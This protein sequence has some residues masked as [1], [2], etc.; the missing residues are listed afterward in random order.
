[1]NFGNVENVLMR[2]V[3]GTP[4]VGGELERMSSEPEAPGFFDSSV[5]NKRQAYEQ[6]QAL[7]AEVIKRNTLYELDRLNNPM[8]LQDVSTITGQP[9]DVLATEAQR[10]IPRYQDRTEQYK[11]EGPQPR[12]MVPIGKEVV[13]TVR[14]LTPV[15]TPRDILGDNPLPEMGAA[16][17]DQYDKRQA[18]YWQPGSQSEDIT[19]DILAPGIV[20][21][22][23]APITKERTVREIAGYDPNPRADASQWQRQLAEAKI[24]QQGLRP[25]VGAG[26][27]KPSS[28]RERYEML[29]PFVGEEEAARIVG[30]ASNI[31]LR[32]QQT[33]GN[34]DLMGAKGENLK[35]QTESLKATMG[36]RADYY[37]TQSDL[38]A[39]RIRDMKDMSSDKKAL[40]QQQVKSGKALEEYHRHRMASGDIELSIRE[41]KLMQSLN[42]S[43][44]KQLIAA[45]KF[46]KDNKQEISGE[47]F[48]QM[49][50]S[51]GKGLG[52]EGGISQAPLTDRIWNTLT[53]NSAENE[54]EPASFV[55]PSQRVPQSDRQMQSESMS[56]LGKATNVPVAQADK[57]LEALEREL[58]DLSKKE[59]KT[60]Q[61]PETGQ[62]YIVKGGHLKRK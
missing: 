47:Q 59:G 33:A 62:K 27:G 45:M 61:D 12:G 19:R 44:R 3:G 22:P 55:L 2:G 58:G 4:G 39:A 21:G 38:A 26:G 53:G 50:D 5:S 28:V 16:A 32:R 10:S 29:V 54:Q 14:P 34:L 31:D 42:E 6:W 36:P 37:K 35:A 17:W 11:E 48:D 56:A 15:M 9:A 60:F 49:I 41:S 25:L 8:S 52:F 23:G 43:D 30:G 20:Q 46:L 51:I 7:K 18:P 1:M 13:D 40:L 24:H 57:E